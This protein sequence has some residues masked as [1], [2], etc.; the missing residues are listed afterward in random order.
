MANLFSE[1]ALAAL[2]SE[3]AEKVFQ[4]DDAASTASGA[5]SDPAS[6]PSSPGI[7]KEVTLASAA[8]SPTRS[9][10]S[11][12]TPTVA[13]ES[14]KDLPSLGS[15]GHFAGLCSRCCFHA[16]G[17][18]QNGHDCRFCHFDHEKRQRKKKIDINAR[19]LLATPV[20]RQLENRGFLNEAWGISAPPTPQHVAPPPTPQYVRA[21]PTQYLSAP[22]GLELSSPHPPPPLNYPMVT[23]QPPPT[24]YG[25]LAPALPRTA[26]PASPAPTSLGPMARSAVEAPQSE[27]CLVVPKLSNSMRDWPVDKVM[28]WL[29]SAGLGHLSK[30]FEQH[31]I[32]GDV[33]LELTS[34]DL[35][36]I[37]IHAFGDKKR[38]LRALARA[39]APVVP[40]SYPPPPSPPPCWQAPMLETTSPWGSCPMPPLTPAL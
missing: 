34:G 23:L 4:N 10:A 30:S 9:P 24:K 8:A 21:P 1:E 11:P 29:T 7:G 13:P 26:P 5:S 40:G 3:L 38:L 35:Q 20:H 22:P 15:L 27:A 2:T 36:E 31:R 33:L 14:L 32:S 39:K 28:D 12:W 16:K 18:C 6:L 25:F 37:G 19:G 17:R